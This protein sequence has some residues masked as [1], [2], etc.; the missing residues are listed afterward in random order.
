MLSFALKRH[1]CMS[2]QAAQFHQPTFELP[3]LPEME[4]IPEMEML[5]KNKR[6]PK[7]ANHG[8]RPCSS[9]MRKLKR[10][11]RSRRSNVN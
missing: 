1:F 2:M 10:K 6:P 4:E 7:K 9:V 11:A 3:M 8:A 5:G